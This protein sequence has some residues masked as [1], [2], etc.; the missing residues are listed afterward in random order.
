MTPKPSRPPG[1]LDDAELELWPIDDLR[2]HPDNPRQGDVGAIREA[3]RRRG[4][5]GA[6][7]VQRSTGLTIAGHHRA[8]AAKAEGLTHVPVL[9][10]D[11]DDLTAL[12]D[13]IGDNR[14]A[15]LATY[16]LEELA[17]TLGSMPTLEN[18]GWDEAQLDALLGRT[19]PPELEDRSLKATGM[20]PQALSTEHT[21][22]GCGATFRKDGA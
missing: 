1:P 3:I 4:F 7:I 8:M 13:L 11:V 9:Q 19:E 18:V 17:A 20:K 6:V 15:D 2:P 5:V 10:A 21:C 12:R 14:W 16:D 22:P